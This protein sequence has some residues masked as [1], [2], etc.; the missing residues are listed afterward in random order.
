MNRRHHIRISKRNHV[1]KKD[2]L[3]G[4]IHYFEDCFSAAWNCDKL[5]DLNR[6]AFFAAVAYTQESTPDEEIS[7]KFFGPGQGHSK[8]ISAEYLNPHDQCHGNQED[9]Q[10]KFFEIL[11]Q[12]VKYFFMKDLP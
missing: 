9:D 6:K 10:D 1:N 4:V 12:P 2:Q 3:E 8:N 11:V 5:L 7:G